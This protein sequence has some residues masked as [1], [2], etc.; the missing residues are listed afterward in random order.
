[1][2][3]DYYSKTLTEAIDMLIQNKDTIEKAVI[4]RYAEFILETSFTVDKIVSHY[5][6]EFYGSLPHKIRQLTNEDDVVSMLLSLR[7]QGKLARLNS[8]TT[9]HSKTTGDSKMTDTSS[10][11]ASLLRKI[12][13]STSLNSLDRFR[14]NESMKL[15]SID[16]PKELVRLS[17]HQTQVQIPNKYPLTSCF[18]EEIYSLPKYVG[19]RGLKTNRVKI[20]VE[21]FKNKQ[22]HDIEWAVAYNLEDNT[23]YRVNGQHTSYLFSSFGF[24]KELP[25]ED[26]PDQLEIILQYYICENIKQIGEL[27]QQFD[28]AASARTPTEVAGSITAQYPELTG[29]SNTSAMCAASGLAWYQHIGE[30]PKD[31]SSSDKLSLIHQNVEYFSWVGKFAG[32]KILK[33]S[34][35]MA[36]VY[37]TW[38]KSP[39]AA[40]S[41][42]TW[43]KKNSHEDKKHPSTVLCEFLKN[44]EM[45]TGSG[46][47]SGGTWSDLAFYNKSILAWNAFRENRRTDLKFYK[48]NYKDEK[49]GKITSLIS[50]I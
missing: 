5:R 18:A 23:L 31:L 35:V 32:A 26:F 28:S 38:K 43:V 36:A 45:R 20:L 7:K 22:I 13:S 47:K 50:A 40:E 3:C 25:G 39:I 19:D 37:A 1:M 2:G 34:P 6:K 48:D 4:N 42:W 14:L 21:K 24:A 9:R 11:I 29:I 30:P 44:N 41:F 10:E 33:R 46:G 15:S 8:K 16:L 27:W 17:H 12:C 49:T